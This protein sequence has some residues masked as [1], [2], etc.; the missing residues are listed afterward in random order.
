[1]A[2]II[3]HIVEG[4]DFTKIAI[5]SII[6]AITAVMMITPDYQFFKI[7]ENQFWLN[8]LRIS[9]N[10]ILIGLMVTIIVVIIAELILRLMDF[11]VSMMG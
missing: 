8:I 1:M 6:S 10:G 2:L 5:A 3:E 9:G 11:I 4:D 7:V